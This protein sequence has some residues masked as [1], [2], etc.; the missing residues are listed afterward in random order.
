MTVGDGPAGD[1]ALP[2]HLPDGRQ[3]AVTWGVPDPFG[4]MTSAM[5][6]RSRAFVRVA[7]RDVDVLTFDPTPGIV[8]LRERLVDA[9]ELVPGIRLRNVYEEPGHAR[10]TPGPIAFRPGHVR[11]DAVD[12]IEARDGTSLVVARRGR[13]RVALEHLRADGTLAVRDERVR[14]RAHHGSSPPTTRPAIRC[15]SGRARGRST[16]TGSTA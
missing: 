8:D 3:F 16:P 7:Q 15:G 10:P 6:H 13:H 12:V 1:D 5:L 9:G 14:N 2:H 11:P 4:G